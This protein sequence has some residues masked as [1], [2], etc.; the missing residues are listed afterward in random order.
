VRQRIDID[1][2]LST[3]KYC[4]LILVKLAA[5]FCP[6]ISERIYQDLKTKNDPKSVHLNNWPEFNRKLIQTKLNH[7]MTVVRDLTSRVLAIR[8][9]ENIRVRQPLAE[10]VIWGEPEKLINNKFLLKLILDETNVEKI[11]IGKRKLSQNWKINT[12]KFSGL[13]LN[14]HV[15]SRLK[16]QGIFR[17]LVREFQQTRKL[18]NLVPQDK[19]KLWLKISDPKLKKIIT[20]KSTELIV[21]ANVKK[22]IFKKTKKIDFEKELNIEG[23]KIWV[24]IKK[25]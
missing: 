15:S 24:G 2:F 14:C 5:P 23:N 1:D 10:L 22:I 21:L 13:A 7:K 6:F 18:A 11:S 16:N 17:E 4:L 12:D 20:K 8:S 3:L 19:I 25:D 9:Q